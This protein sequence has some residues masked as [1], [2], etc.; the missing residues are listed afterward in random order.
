MKS[1][2]FVEFIKS[3]VK[4]YNKKIKMRIVPSN[5]WMFDINCDITDIAIEHSPK[6]IFISNAFAFNDKEY[7]NRTA[8]GLLNS[9]SNKPD[10]EVAFEV[11]GWNGK[12]NRQFLTEY[13]TLENIAIEENDD[14][15]V[16]TINIES[17]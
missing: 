6:I 13:P 3:A 11:Y 1:N 17:I 8:W 4:G 12:S 16:I 14:Y 10:Y 9:L 15:V 7:H 5:G 2:K